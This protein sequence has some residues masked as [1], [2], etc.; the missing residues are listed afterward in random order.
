MLVGEHTT[1]WR[2]FPDLNGNA[3]GFY[4]QNING[5]RVVAHGG[6]IRVDSTP[7]DGTTFT[8]RL[9]RHAAASDALAAVT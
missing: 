5:H 7:R 9:P 8:V 2:A 6:D 3:L 1:I 4:Q